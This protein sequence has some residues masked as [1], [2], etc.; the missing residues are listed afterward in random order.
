MANK[1]PE[2]LEKP[3][4][5]NVYFHAKVS[6]V[7]RVQTQFIPFLVVFPQEV[8]RKLEQVHQSYIQTELGL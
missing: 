5:G 2:D 3:L 4:L 8:K 1:R 6:C 7:K